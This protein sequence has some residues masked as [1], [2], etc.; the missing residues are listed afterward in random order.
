VCGIMAFAG[1]RNGPTIV[2]QGLARLEYRGYDSWGIAARSTGSIACAKDVGKLGDVPPEMLDGDSLS[3]AIGHVRWATHGGVTQANAHPHL[4]QDGRI[5]VVH[6]GIIENYQALRRELRAEGVV[7]ESET[8]TEVIPH[9]ISRELAR[10]H[11]L[12]EATR[13]ALAQVEGSFAVAVI[14]RDSRILIGARRYSPLVLGVGDE[15][16]YLAS[17]V[18]AFLAY[19]R[20]A[21][22]LEENHMAI[23]EVDDAGGHNYRLVDLETGAPVRLEPTRIEW[24]VEQAEKAGHPHFTIKEILEQPVVLDH[25]AS[26]SDEELLAAAQMLREARHVYVVACGTALHAGIYASYIFSTNNGIAV[27]PISAG[28][29]PYFSGLLKPGDLMLTISQSGETAD[30]MASVRTARKAGAKVLALVNVMGSSLMR[31]ADVSLL[32][33][34]GPEISVVSTKAYLSQLS[35]LTLL[36]FALNGVPEAGRRLLTA[37]RGELEGI[38]GEESRERVRELAPLIARCPCIY[39]IGRGVDY[40]TALE[41]CLK[42]KEISYIHAEG[43]AAGDLKHGPLALVEP[44]IPVFALASDEDWAHETLSNATEAKA[45]GGTLIGVSC[46]E[47]EV[48]DHFFPVRANG[49]YAAIPAIVYGQLLAYYIALEKGLDPDKPRNLAKSVTVK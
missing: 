5:A 35:M 7:F 15:G 2:A 14:D 34:A 1:R 12:S 23:V 21:V 39:A 16:C 26:T 43:F 33:K 42:I 48:F 10:T 31:A 27:R 46:C 4:S 18:P 30:V 13:A 24:D 25:V 47:N 8:D 19:T 20:T 37:I 22:F 41:W 28:E 36:S 40:P 9:L 3:P 45:R 17:D 29:F 38:L 11:S 49:P 32:T 44:G 6:N